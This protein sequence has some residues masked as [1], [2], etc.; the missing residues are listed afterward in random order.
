MI[1]V[2]DH[3]YQPRGACR[4]LFA[5][6]DPEVLLS[7]PAG[8]GKSRGCLEKLH[9][10]ALVNPGMRGLI[11]RKTATS[12]TS[13][14]LVT[15][16]EQVAKEALETGLVTWFGGSAQEAAAYRYSNGS[17][18]AVGGMDKATRIMSSEYDVAYV[19]EAIE[20]SEND[21]EAITTRLRNGRVTF[22]QI[23]ADTNPDM[24]T[25]W[26]KQRGNSGRT[27][28]LES[29]HED[30]PMLFGEDGRLTLRGV[31][32]I[33]K[34]DALSGPRLARLRRGLWVA[35]EGVIYESYDPAV[36]LVDRFEIPESWTRWWSVD[37]GYTN[38]FVLQ[39]WA[40]DP[41][42]RL[43]LY[44]EQYMTKRLVEDHAADVLRD[45]TERAPGQPRVASDT[46]SG[47][48][49][50]A[51]VAAGRRRWTEP[52]PRSIIC[53]HDAEDRATLERHLGLSTSPAHKSVSD[54]IQAVQSRLKASAE[55]KPRILIMRDSVARR[56]QSLVDAKRPAST[57]EEIPGYVWESNTKERP[58]KVDDHGS[59]AMRY[60][61][62]EIDLGGRPN[63]RWM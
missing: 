13:T 20:L 49:I 30:N 1:A 28:I 31:D 5:C 26:L 55:V 8:T 33:G 52:R 29:R 48:A 6:R 39:R 15:W 25:H 16:R 53:D 40:E 12:L 27:T 57:A 54:G 22:Q 21:W 7:G 51:A 9:L 37:F 32:Y 35:A 10:M 2:I 56:D 4:D 23:I 61:V 19:Q 46:E 44:A 47:Q 11:V 36:H 17:I 42:G 62:A 14:A 34:L 38:P 50:L 24:P 3:R 63:V 59:D 60:V 45:V 41:D 43:V 58:L 18:I